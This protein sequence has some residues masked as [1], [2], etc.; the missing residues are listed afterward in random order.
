MINKVLAYMRQYSM[1][2]A[3]GNI[4]AGVSGG[5]DSVCL[6]LVLVRL[7]EKLG[8]HLS[9]V[10]I[11]HG[12]RAEA[13]KDAE[14]VRSLCEKWDVPVIIHET[15]VR[16]LAEQQ[17]TGSEEAGR[18]ARYAAFMEQLKKMDAV[19]GGHGCIAVAHNR[20][21]RAETF[22]FHLLRGTGLDGM[23]GIRPVRPAADAAGPKMRAARAAVEAGGY[24]AAEREAGTPRIIRPLLDTERKEIE[25]FLRAE[26]VGWRTDATNEEDIYTRNRIRNRILP[27]AEKFICS[28]AKEHLAGEAGLLAQ[29]ADYIRG[30]TLDALERCGEKAGEGRGIIRISVNRLRREEPFIQKQCV[31]EC[32]LRA[33]TGRDLSAAH[34]EAAA[35]LAAPASQSGKRLRL[36]LCRVEVTRE[37]DSLLFA[38]IMS[39]TGADAENIPAADPNEME[40]PLVL[41]RFLVPGLGVVRTQLLRERKIN[42]EKDPDQAFFLK[43]IP[44]KKYTKWID[45][46]KIIE[47]A[48]F[49]TRRRGDYLTI[50]ESLDKK[51]LKKYMIEEKIPS[52]ERDRLILLADGAH[53]IWM[54]GHRI[55]AA[56]K[57]TRQTAAILEIHVSVRPAAGL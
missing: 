7:R 50:N 31:R 29:T 32:L 49:R 5:P 15:D 22:L 8:L 10:H 27:Y 33:G 48:V 55:S 41:G 21:D 53:I 43:N 51:S 56:Y 25:A 37:F 54:P 30:Q 14:F 38:P 19:T 4:V 13:G 44:Q 46:D 2:P 11:N 39:K 36:P 20:D 24:A 45:Y 47:S 26:H 52:D 28:G 23:A 16:K 34:V 18:R 12:L 57:V 35:A 17:K 42:G 3:N 1:I 6:L 9:A 40:T